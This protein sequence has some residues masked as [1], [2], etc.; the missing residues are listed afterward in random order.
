MTSSKRSSAPCP[1]QSRLS[2]SRKP[3]AG[4]TT[5]M[6]PA[7]G[8]TTITA[9]SRPRADIR[10]ST[11]SRSLNGTVKVI[12]ASAAGTPRLS[13]TPKV[14]PPA[15]QRLAPGLDHRRRGV[16][17]DER[18]PRAQEV[19]VAASVHVGDAAALP[20]RDEEGRAADAAEGADGA[21][22]AAWDHALRLLE[23]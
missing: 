11:A 1:S 19:E 23:E 21:V 15:P 17:E 12:W 13:G 2:P 18:T 10:R 14:A 9:T 4:G 22:D 7:T 6:L 5:P 8:S 20:A 3:G 16:T